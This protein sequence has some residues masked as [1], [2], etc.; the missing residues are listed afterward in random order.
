MEET[1]GGGASDSSAACPRFVL[2]TS[3][4]PPFLLF[5]SW[6]TGLLPLHMIQALRTIQSFGVEQ[7][8]GPNGI[9]GDWTPWSDD[10]PRAYAE[11][12]E[13]RS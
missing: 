1:G 5:S 2:E 6:R 4:A 9:A 12:S 10:E 3:L 8:I 7:I 11:R 13:L